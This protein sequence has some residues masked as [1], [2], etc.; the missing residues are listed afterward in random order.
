MCE[1]YEGFIDRFRTAY[2]AEMKAFIEYVLGLRT[3]PCTGDEA[4]EALRVALA[5]KRSLDNGGLRVKLEEV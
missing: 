2:E 1:P 4:L 5:C 3:N